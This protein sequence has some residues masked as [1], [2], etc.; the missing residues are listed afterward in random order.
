MDAK[1]IA[2]LQSIYYSDAKDEVDERVTQLEAKKDDNEKQGKMAGFIAWVFIRTLHLNFPYW[3]AFL[4]F[5][6]F[7]NTINSNRSK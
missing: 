7:G 6:T 5:A 1:L 3:Q 4:Y 2:T